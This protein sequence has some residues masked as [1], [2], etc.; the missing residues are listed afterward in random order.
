MTTTT[1]RTKAGAIVAVLALVLS[2]FALSTGTPASAEAPSD[3]SSQVAGKSKTVKT[4]A[5]NYVA[6]VFSANA[7]GQTSREC[8][9]ALISPQ[10]VLA[11]ANCRSAGVGENLF[12]SIG[13]TNFAKNKDAD[14]D[15]KAISQVVDH[16]LASD[17]WA[18]RAY[19]MALYKLDSKTNRRPAVVGALPG[20][21]ATVYDYGPTTTAGTNGGVL[22]KGTAS[23]VGND[24]LL[25]VLRQVDGDTSTAPVDHMMMQ[26]ATPG[27]EAKPCLAAGAP[28][29]TEIKGVP[30]V[31]GIANELAIVGSN[32]R[33][34]ACGLALG[35]YIHFYHR[36]SGKT[37]TDWIKST[38]GKTG[39]AKD[40][41]CRG[42][43]ATLFG[44]NASETITGTNGNDVIFAANGNDKIVGGK[45]ADT[46]CGGGGND[47]LVGGKGKDICDGGSGNDKAK[48][49]C[50]TK[51]KI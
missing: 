37:T 3:I 11:S 49:N 15:L 23:I 5:A 50:E 40:K 16:P 45:G 48:K 36:L 6:L 8:H 31:V 32:N 19:D 30:T 1:S 2:T 12:V 29:I 14:F 4:G 51:K 41:K 9:G 22:R 35:E 46:L 34:D 38:V 10:W 33:T 39:P 24:S 47:L 26:R 21:K 42:K 44:T 7:A 43:L 25:E 13:A 20:N 17:R 27:S 28:L 18:A